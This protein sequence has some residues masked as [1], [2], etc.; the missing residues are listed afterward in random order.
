MK[1][2]INGVAWSAAIRAT[3]LQ[4][5]KFIINGTG[6]LGSDVINVTIF[7]I[8]TG[9]YNLD[10]INS[11]TQFSA[12]YTIDTQTTDSIYTALNGMVIL[13]TVDTINHKISGTFLFTAGKVINPLLIK[14]V[15]E[16]IF[17]DLSYQ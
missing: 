12:S 15:S 14:E 7:G 13:S 11:Q 17:T 9:T 6:S 8:T 4:S 1:C 2:K 5:N 16:G 10:P 3:T